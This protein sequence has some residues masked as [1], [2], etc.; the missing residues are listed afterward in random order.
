MAKI[1]KSKVADLY[2]AK[3]DRALAV[4]RKKVAKWMPKYDAWM[5]DYTGTVEEPKEII[6]PLDPTIRWFD[7]TAHYAISERPLED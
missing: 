5:D 6:H 3:L 1:S 7:T 2:A 4:F